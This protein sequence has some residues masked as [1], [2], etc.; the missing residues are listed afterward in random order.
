M[1]TEC[2][3][4]VIDGVKEALQ[5]PGVKDFVKSFQEDSTS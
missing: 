1:G 5:S 2:I 3:A 4:W